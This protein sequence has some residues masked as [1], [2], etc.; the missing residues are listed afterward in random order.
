VYQLEKLADFRPKTLYLQSLGRSGAL[1][2][3]QA[4]TWDALYTQE[5]SER[6]A[7]GW[8]PFSR[9]TK[10]SHTTNDRIRAERAARVLAERLTRAAAHLGI[11]RAVSV[12]GPMP[13]L[14]ERAGG[15][16]TQ[17]ILLKSTGASPKITSLLEHVPTG[18]TIDIDPRS[19]T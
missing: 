11:T 16:W 3:A 17:H 15:R 18:W 12:L 9:L 2:H 19:I 6:K 5:L 14:L 7:L 8:P 13:A 4:R 10:L 1:A